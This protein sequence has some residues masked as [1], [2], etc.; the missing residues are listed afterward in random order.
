MIIAWEAAVLTQMATASITFTCSFITGVG[1]SWGNRIYCK[2]QPENKN[3]FLQ[4]QGAQSGRKK[5]TGYFSLELL[6]PNKQGQSA[7][8]LAQRRCLLRKNHSRNCTL[9]SWSERRCLPA[10]HS[11]PDESSVSAAGRSMASPVADSG[12]DQL[13]APYPEPRRWPVSFP[14]GSKNSGLP[15][16]R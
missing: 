1:Q 15:G 14:G 3:N 11:W 10:S 13:S 2:P 12:P 7:G 5:E 9:I 8:L 6:S 16:C 4:H